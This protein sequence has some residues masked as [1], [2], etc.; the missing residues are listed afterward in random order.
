MRLE[1]LKRDMSPFFNPEVFR[2]SQTIAKDPSLNTN[3]DRNR[4]LFIEKWGG[5]PGQET[6]K[7]PYNK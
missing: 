3:F 7:S 1:G 2:N 4:N 6:Y 5:S